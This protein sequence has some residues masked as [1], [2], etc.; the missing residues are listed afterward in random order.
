MG[1]KGTCDICGADRLQHG[2]YWV[3]PGLWH[4]KGFDVLCMGDGSKADNSCAMKFDRVFRPLS[5]EIIK[6][7]QEAAGQEVGEVAAAQLEL[8]AESTAFNRD[9]KS[10][11]GQV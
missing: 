8:I 5:K 9:G 11:K 10:E 3:V 4:V 7:H 6:K 2:E 1:L